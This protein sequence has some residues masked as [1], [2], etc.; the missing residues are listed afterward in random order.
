[1]RYVLLSD[2]HTT[3]KMIFEESKM[4]RKQRCRNKKILKK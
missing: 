2:L 4:W 3:E 1:L